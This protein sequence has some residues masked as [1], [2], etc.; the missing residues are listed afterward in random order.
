MEEKIRV[1]VVDDNDINSF[2]LQHIIKAKFEAVIDIATDGKEAVDA[3]NEHKY[4]IIFMDIEMPIMNGI[5]ASSYIKEGLN[6]DT[7]IVYVSAYL[8]ENIQLNYPSFDTNV[9]MCNKPVKAQ[10]IHNYIIKATT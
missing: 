1:L 2:L 6:K 9:P 8:P 7:M 5:D 3:A 10:C 4:D